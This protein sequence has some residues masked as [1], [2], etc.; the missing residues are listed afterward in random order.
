VPKETAGRTLYVTLV[1]CAFCSVLVA[2]AAVVLRPPQEANKLLDRKRNILMAAGLLAEGKSVDELFANI[3]ARVVDLATGEYAKGIDPEAFDQRQAAKDPVQSVDIPLEKDLAG[4]KRRAK[5]APVYL[6]RGSEEVVKIIL[7]VYGKGLWSTLYGF[8]ALDAKDLST[9]QALVFYEHAETPGL[10]GEVDNPNW[11]AQWK[12]K[13]AFDEK[14]SIRIEVIKG[15]V[16]PGRP[17]AKYQV[18]GIS[19]A[20]ITTRGVKNMLRYWLGEDGFGPYLARLKA[21]GGPH[22]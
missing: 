2:G 12:G 4:N 22:G 20:S 6:V 1:V 21:R 10:G 19:G 8:L 7:P 15:K 14:G 13:E 3:D 5:L 16:D 11:R 18:D 17:E 9:I